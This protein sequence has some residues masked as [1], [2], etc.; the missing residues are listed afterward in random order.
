MI[1]TTGLFLAMLVFCGFA[2][3]AMAAGPLPKRACYSLGNTLGNGD[4][5]NG[6]LVL[7]I[8]KTG[9]WV[10]DGAR[11][12]KYYQVW[13]TIGVTGAAA[14]IEVNG[15]G[16]RELGTGRFL[17]Q[18]HGSY[19]GG[20]VDCSFALES[21]GNTFYCSTNLVGELYTGVPISCKNLT[22]R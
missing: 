3:Q 17:G 5:H 21:G 7:T 22:L 9:T 12:V 11:K 19:L 8:K 2:L 16:H 1:R 20:V 18:I 6:P 10:R 14:Y 15:S 13:G 4:F